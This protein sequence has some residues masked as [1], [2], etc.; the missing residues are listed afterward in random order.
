MI[1][2]KGFSFRYRE[3][4]DF[5]VSDVDLSVAAGTF[6]GIT[7]AAGSGKSTLTYALNGVVPHCYP[8]DFYGSV[9]VD[10][11]DTCETRLTDL[12]RI[13]GSVCQDIESQMVTAVVEDE[14][15]FGLEN[16]GIEPSEIEGRLSEA[17]LSVGIADLRHRAISTLSGGQKQKVALA[18]ILALRPRVLMLDE[19]TS[20]LDPVSS[21]AVF[22]FLKSYAAENRAC[23][24][25]VE[26]KIGLLA[27]FADDMVVMDEGR[28]ALH[29]APTD[30]LKRP[31]RLFDLGVNVPRSTELSNELTRR[32]LYEG[33][34]CRSVE[35]AVRAAREVL[36]CSNSG[37]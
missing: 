29:G 34:V 6:L 18:S 31:D 32:G 33:P 37:E 17:L 12:S 4:S 14:V 20:E 11:N 22:S 26:Q 15:L 9:A 36:A 19:P 8:G 24:V 16:F 30:L 35:E 21:R 5:A 10:G 2:M 1:E 3:R 27:E 13:V 23:V 7:G 28:V 25:A